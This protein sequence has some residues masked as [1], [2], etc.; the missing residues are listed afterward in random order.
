MNI[1]Q[2]ITQI[3][4]RLKIKTSKEEVEIPMAD[5]IETT[6]RKPLKTKKVKVVSL[7]SKQ[8]KEPEPTVP[9]PEPLETQ[10]EHEENRWLERKRKSDAEKTRRGEENRKIAEGLLQ[11]N[12]KKWFIV[13]KREIDEEDEGAFFQRTKDIFKLPGNSDGVVCFV[14]DTN[15]YLGEKLFIEGVTLLIKRNAI[16]ALLSRNRFGTYMK[17]YEEPLKGKCF[18]KHTYLDIGRM[19]DKEIK[20]EIKEAEKIISESLR[21]IAYPGKGSKLY[22]DDKDEERCEIAC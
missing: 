1:K 17:I 22:I 18:N 7:K 20:E 8:E 10:Q 5:F 13:T 21:K 6:T 16:N 12:P 15:Q 9:E 2:T 11:K 19:S 3:L 4:S 14:I